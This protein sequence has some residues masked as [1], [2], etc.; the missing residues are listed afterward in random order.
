MNFTKIVVIGG[1]V[2][3]ILILLR[4]MLPWLALILA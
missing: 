2:I 4:K 1:I 3:V